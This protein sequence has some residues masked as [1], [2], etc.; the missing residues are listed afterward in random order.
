MKNNEELKMHQIVECRIMR[1]MKHVNTEGV[2]R[3]L[4]YAFVEFKKHELALKTLRN[5]NNNPKVFDEIKR[6]IVE[7]SLENT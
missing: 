3:S 1:D 4:G 5:M 6:P 7:F 2:G